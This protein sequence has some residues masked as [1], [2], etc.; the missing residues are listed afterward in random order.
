MR[1]N[2]VF[3]RSTRAT[4]VSRAASVSAPLAMLPTTPSSHVLWPKS[5]PGPAKKVQCE[6][7]RFQCERIVAFFNVHISLYEYDILYLAPSRLL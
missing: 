7:V 3:T 4:A 2:R 1:P 5:N 6:V